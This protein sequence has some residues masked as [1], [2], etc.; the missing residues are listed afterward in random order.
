MITNQ[1]IVT[2]KLY[3]DWAAEDRKKGL[4]LK[5][6]ILWA[7]I[8]VILIAATVVYMRM[9]S[10]GNGDMSLLLVLEGA[11]LVFTVYQLFFRG[12][13]S[14]GAMYD[15]IAAQLGHDW[16]RTMHFKNDALYISEGSFEIN[17]PYSEIVSVKN[18]GNEI[19]IETDKKLVLHAYKD[20]FIEGDYSRFKRFIESKVVNKCF[21]N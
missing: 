21:L 17:Y 14:A 4:S 18:I 9:R 2:K 1:Y 5:I 16:T 15:K 8:L 11:L 20:K 3:M 12:K 7:V 13:S 19:M 10:E 6:N